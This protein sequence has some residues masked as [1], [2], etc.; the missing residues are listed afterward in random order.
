MVPA[1]DFY[2][3]GVFGKV[4]IAIFYN[5][6]N[7][8]IEGLKIM[9]KQMIITQYTDHTTLFL[10]NKEDISAG[11]KSIN[12]FSK[13]ADVKLITDKCKILALHEQQAESICISYQEQRKHNFP[14]HNT[15]LWNDRYTL[16]NL[17]SLFLGTWMEK[18]I[19]AVSQLLDENGN[20]LN[21]QI[22]VINLTFSVHLVNIRK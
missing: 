3:K 22:A 19:W 13:A 8:R 9:G 10:K 7:N 4:A 18:G 14:P 2:L 5:L 6:K 17:K 21:L 1:Q 20:F 15:P 11:L 12:E 16:I